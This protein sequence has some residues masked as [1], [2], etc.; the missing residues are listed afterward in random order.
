MH[1]TVY[2]YT[3]T[4]THTH[5]HKYLN[6]EQNRKRDLIERKL[7]SIDESG[8][9]QRTNL[10]NDDLLLGFGVWSIAV[11]NNDDDRWLHGEML[12][13]RIAEIERSKKWIISK[14]KKFFYSYF[15]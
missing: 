8:D 15:V 11:V 10:G 1:S 3:H 6:H 12:V 14:K 7:S 9:E 5:T 4:H 13:R 2:K